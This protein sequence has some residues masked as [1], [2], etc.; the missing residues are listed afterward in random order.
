[1]RLTEN[2]RL[3]TPAALLAIALV[4]SGCGGG[5]SSSLI[6]GGRLS[7]NANIGEAR[8]AAAQAEPKSGSV[9]QSSD[10]E[11]GVTRDVVKVTIAGAD[12]TKPRVTATYNGVEVVDTADAT[13]RSGVS[14][15]LGEP[16]KQYFERVTYEGTQGVEFYRGLQEGDLAGVPAGDIWVDAY[17]DFGSDPDGDG[18]AVGETDWLAGGIWVYIPAGGTAADYEFG[19]FADG[20][21]PLTGTQL[22]GIS[23]TAS[24]LG[25]ATGVYHEGN[26]NYFFDAGVTLGADFSNDT[27]SGSVHTF[28]LDG[29][30]VAG[31]PVLTLGSASF[32]SGNFFKGGTS[33]TYDGASYSGKWGGQFYNFT[34]NQAGAAGGTFGAAS[35]NGDSLVGVFGSYKQ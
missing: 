3:F 11:G 2:P 17:T 10:T 32:A 34:S 5:G 21:D 35:G 14:G 15:V 24:Y 27:I 13:E 28:T 4:A 31:S 18:A 19:A 16:G 1:M 22:S 30:A 29:Q 7:P 12:P 23:G 9:T 20:A 25:A 8:V 6:P 26:R 33:M